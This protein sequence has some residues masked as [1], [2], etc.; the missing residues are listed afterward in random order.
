MALLGRRVEGPDLHGRDAFTQQRLGQFIRMVQKALQVFVGSVVVGQAPVGTG[1]VGSAAD[2]LVT[3]AGVVDTDA[4]A[5]FAAQCGVHRQVGGFAKNIPQRN[6]HRRVAPR[7]HTRPAP[8]QVAG[9]VAV[10]G[11]DLQRVGANQ[12]GCRPFVQIGFDRLCTHE[13]F[14]QPHQA[15]IGVQAHPEDV[16]ELAEADGFELGDFHGISRR[17]LSSMRPSPHSLHRG[18]WWAHSCHTRA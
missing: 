15:F 5:A 4:V 2:V 17:A 9:D 12:L 18:Q 3:R 11:L 6:V 16:G 1:L 7:L 10:A 14:T 13:S 8:A